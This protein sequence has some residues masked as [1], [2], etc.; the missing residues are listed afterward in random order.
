LFFGRLSYSYSY[1]HLPPC[2][3]STAP[4]LPHP[5]SLLFFGR[6]SYP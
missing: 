4:F 3:F 2:F 6:L 5:K 1:T